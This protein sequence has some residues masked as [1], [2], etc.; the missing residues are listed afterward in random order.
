MSDAVHPSSPPAAAQSRHNTDDSPRT[1]NRGVPRRPA[2]P[3]SAARPVETSE[4]RP[5]APPTGARSWGGGYTLGSGMG[6][7]F[8]LGS[9]N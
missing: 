5:E 8:M 2:Q 7:G 6:G 3:V 4:A 1:R 9:G